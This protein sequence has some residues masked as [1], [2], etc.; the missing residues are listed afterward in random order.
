MGLD[1]GN[2]ACANGYLAS[3]SVPAKSPMQLCGP[4]PC[5]ETRNTGSERARRNLFQESHSHFTQLDPR[6][7]KK[8][9]FIVIND[10]SQLLDVL[11][12]DLVDGVLMEL[13]VPTPRGRACRNLLNNLRNHIWDFEK[14]IVEETEHKLEMELKQKLQE[15]ERGWYEAWQTIDGNFDHLNLTKPPDELESVYAMRVNRACDE[16]IYNASLKIEYYENGL[17]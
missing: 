1:T 13:Q 16:V 3:P 4:L 9:F 5:P 2:H 14:Q 12:P 8:A 6:F 17:Q 11:P 7:A 10:D 15:V